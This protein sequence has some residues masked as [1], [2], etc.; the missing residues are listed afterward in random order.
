MFK[1]GHNKAEAQE[2]Q[3]RSSRGMHLLA[4]IGSEAICPE[5]RAFLD[6]GGQQ[7]HPI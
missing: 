2:G 7:D 5:Q 6:D 3:P 1:V 4:G